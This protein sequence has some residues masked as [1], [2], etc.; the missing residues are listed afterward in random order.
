MTVILLGAIHI[1]GNRWSV[2]LGG[3]GEI[4]VA[5]PP[6]ANTAEDAINA[7]EEMIS[8][9]PEVQASID[10]R[11]FRASLNPYR[12]AFREAMFRTPFP[13]APHMLA[14]F[15]AAVAAARAQDPYSPLVKW[16]D[17]VTQIIRLHPDMDAFGAAFGLSTP[18]LDA[19]CQLAMDIEKGAA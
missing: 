1:E 4:E 18:D 7:V 15:D 6:D 14:A 2:I 16:A 10:L 12:R 8:P 9:P 5:L 11:A 19:L 13:N 3:G 17:D